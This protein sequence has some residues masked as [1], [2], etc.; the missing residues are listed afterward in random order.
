MASPQPGDGESALS[1]VYDDLVRE[2]DRLR[3]ARRSVTSQ[4]GPLPAAS[5]IV[6][7]LFG[8]LG[9]DIHGRMTVLFVIALL[10]LVAIAV[11]SSIAITYLPYRQIRRDA[12]RELEKQ[13]GKVMRISGRASGSLRI[14]SSRRP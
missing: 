8:A 5:A 11:V 10:M 4:L 3:D 7:A 13:V 6:L 2:R 12:V 14:S 1:L 9:P